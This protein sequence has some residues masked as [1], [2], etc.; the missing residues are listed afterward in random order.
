MRAAFASADAGLRDEINAHVVA[1]FEPTGIEKSREE[2]ENGRFDNV[3][4]VHHPFA[5]NRKAIELRVVFLVS[6]ENCF[7]IDP[8]R[9]RVVRRRK[10]WTRRKRRVRELSRERHPSFN[11]DES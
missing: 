7:A 1:R 8:L 10:R 2:G 4:D 11:E 5:A 6:S 3:I 9:R